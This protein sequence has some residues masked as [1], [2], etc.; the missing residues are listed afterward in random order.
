MILKILLKGEKE[1]VIE[2]DYY[3]DENEFT[4]YYLNNEIVKSF[5]KVELNK[6]FMKSMV[7]SLKGDEQLIIEVDHY[8]FE[9]GFHYFYMN[10]KKV[11]SFY[12]EDIHW[13][14]DNPYM[15]K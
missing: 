6:I 3:Q 9:D 2:Y 7:V 14:S 11:R 13:V 12:E 1:L 15:K 5:Q 4:N 8:R 10:G